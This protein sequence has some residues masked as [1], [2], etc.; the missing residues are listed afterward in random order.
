LPSPGGVPDGDA[1]PGTPLKVDL[2]AG[3]DISLTWDTACS[4]GADDYSVYEGTIGGD[5]T[6]HGSKECTTGGATSKTLT[7][8][9][10]DDR[11]YIVVPL[12]ADAE[13][14]YGTDSD[15][16][17][18]VQGASPCKATKKPTLCP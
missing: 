2:A 4:A 6:S 7:P 12:N 14:S 17:E 1:L 9:A 3:S 8:T 18:R 15:T 5:F 11:Y 13:G 10:G 16:T